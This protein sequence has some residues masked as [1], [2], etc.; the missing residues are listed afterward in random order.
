[1]F[2]IQFLLMSFFFSIKLL[3]WD[4]PPVFLLF[5]GLSFVLKD[6]A[7][8]D[9]STGFINLNVSNNADYCEQS[10]YDNNPV[11]SD[12]FAFHLPHHLVSETITVRYFKL[13][14]AYPSSI[15]H[16]KIVSLFSKPNTVNALP[17]IF[18]IKLSPTSLAL[19]AL[20]QLYCVQ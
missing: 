17:T 6:L 9:L 1:M 19:S 4:I 10:W 18:P 20:Q 16:L 5:H 7:N 2:C 15:T 11:S 8:A 12:W 14:L 3:I 13:F